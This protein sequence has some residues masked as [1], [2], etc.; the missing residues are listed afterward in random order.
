[1]TTSKNL[2][3]ETYTAQGLH[4]MDPLTGSVVP[5]IMPSTTFARDESYQLV[6]Q[7]HS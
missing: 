7:E 5:P 6:A 1:M 2:A 3:P 4:Y